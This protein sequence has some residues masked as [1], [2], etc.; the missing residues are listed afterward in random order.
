MA[1]DQGTD[2]SEESSKQLTT[3]HQKEQ[4]MASA[5]A[6]R[7]GPYNLRIERLRKAP[8]WEDLMKE[9]PEKSIKRF[10]NLMKQDEA[11]PNERARKKWRPEK[12]EGRLRR[13]SEGDNDRGMVSLAQTQPGQRRG[14]GARSGGGRSRGGGSDD[15]GDGF[16]GGL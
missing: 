11:K 3:L 12:M 13:T 15:D 8:R 5:Q 1:G 9:D 6:S 7:H 14:S 4:A 10:E 16:G 2:R